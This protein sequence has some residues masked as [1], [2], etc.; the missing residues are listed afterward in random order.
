M[1]TKAETK[2]QAR[3]QASKILREYW[4]ENEF[5]DIV[6]TAN[7]FGITV[8][9]GRINEGTPIVSRGARSAGVFYK[10]KDKTPTICVDIQSEA[11]DNYFAIAHMIGHCV[12]RR[13]KGENT[14][15]FDYVEKW[16]DLPWSEAREERF[17]NYFASYLLMPEGL[18]N[19]FRGVD[20][21]FLNAARMFD[22]SSE[23]LAHRLLFLD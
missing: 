5:P 7:A 6:K 21:N 19:R 4:G 12:E 20:Q 13:M 11:I 23:V 15:A 1:E 16:R 9:A 14:E 18:F 8:K 17:A 3:E 10:D 22:V 2:E